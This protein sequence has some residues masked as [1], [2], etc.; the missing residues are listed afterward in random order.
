[1]SDERLATPSRRDTPPRRNTVGVGADFRD[2]SMDAVEVLPRG[3]VVIY[4]D[5]AHRNGSERSRIAEVVG[6]TIV[7]PANGD[8]WVGVLLPTM[9]RSVDMILCASVT[10]IV[11]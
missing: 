3:A 5:G 1:M 10:K 6:P 2:V 8:A 11:G 4:V 9:P 7:D